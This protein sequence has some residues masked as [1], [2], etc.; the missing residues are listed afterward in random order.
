MRLQQNGGLIIV[1][2]RKCRTGT[3]AVMKYKINIL[4]LKVTQII[5]QNN[6]QFSSPD[7][8]IFETDN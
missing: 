1:L 3:K 6:L 5:E 7:N 2:R 8:K 4:D